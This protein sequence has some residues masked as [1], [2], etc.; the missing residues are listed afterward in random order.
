MGMRTVCDVKTVQH[1][2]TKLLSPKPL[3]P[4]LLK[5]RKFA[6]AL[7]FGVPVQLK[8]TNSCQ[9]QHRKPGALI[10]VRSC[11]DRGGN[12]C[13]CKAAARCCCHP[14]STRQPQGL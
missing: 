5:A 4:E 6:L 8:A 14:S 2:Q 11:S 7:P 3:L 10:I 9:V 1:Q 13:P 12:S